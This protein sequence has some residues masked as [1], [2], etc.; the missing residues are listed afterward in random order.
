VTDFFFSPAW[1]G[2]AEL[3]LKTNLDVLLRPLIFLF[4]CIHMEVRLLHLLVEYPCVTTVLYF[5]LVLT[6]K[7]HSSM[8]MH[9]RPFI[10]HLHAN[11]L[12]PI[13][14][15][16]TLIFMSPYLNFRV[17]YLRCDEQL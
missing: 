2:G 9:C 7:Y 16:F 4:R 8:S 10:K 1:A 15:S 17:I 12:S 5:I 14:W 13:C 6:S 11:A 3:S